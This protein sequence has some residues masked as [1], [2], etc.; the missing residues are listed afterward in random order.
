MSQEVPPAD[1]E[2]AEQKYQETVATHYAFLQRL[3]PDGKV[4]IAHDP[5]KPQPRKSRRNSPCPCG[6]G[7]KYKNC[8]GRR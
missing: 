1:L 6:S 5:P 4:V 3:S 7:K 8:H 2:L